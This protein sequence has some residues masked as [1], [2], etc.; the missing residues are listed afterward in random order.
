MIEFNCPHCGLGIHAKDSAAGKKGNC[1]KCGK[2]IKVP[3]APA[4]QPYFS[5]VVEEPEPTT[6]RSKTPKTHPGIQED[7]AEIPT[8]AAMPGR[9]RLMAVIRGGIGL[10]MLAISG[11]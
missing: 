7:V 3:E 6:T 2:A 10:A 9:D 11:W 5:G 4:V 8:S 1:K